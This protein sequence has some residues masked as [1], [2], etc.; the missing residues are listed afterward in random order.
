VCLVRIV[1]L[2]CVYPRESMLMCFVLPEI[3]TVL[4]FTATFIVSSPTASAAPIRPPWNHMMRYT[5]EPPILLAC[6]SSYNDVFDVSWC[7]RP[8][9]V[10]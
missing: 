5:N 3:Q 8:H 9:G 6:S 1:M 7:C 10:Y 2:S 4:V